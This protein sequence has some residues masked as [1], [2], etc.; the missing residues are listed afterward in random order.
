MIMT[1]IY[2]RKLRLI[3]QPLHSDASNEVTLKCLIIWVYY[4]FS[5]SRQTGH[6]VYSCVQ[7]KKKKS[8]TNTKHASWKSRQVYCSHANILHYSECQVC[9]FAYSF[10]R[11]LPN[12]PEGVCPNMYFG[13]VTSAS[14]YSIGK[15]F[16]RRRKP[17]KLFY[18]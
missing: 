6:R 16:F 14:A 15:T 8:P 12:F 18:H 5:Y 4:F 9:I 17:F 11:C 13:T 10:L 7:K 2:R 3:L 1:V